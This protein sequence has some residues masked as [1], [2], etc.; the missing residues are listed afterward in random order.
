MRDPESRII[1]FLC[2]DFVEHV[3][4]NSLLRNRRKITAVDIET[5]AC[6]LGWDFAS[7]GDDQGEASFDQLDAKDLL[8]LATSRMYEENRESHGLAC[9]TF[10]SADWK[11]TSKN[12]N[13][14]EL[15]EDH[16][17]ERVLPD[18]LKEFVFQ[19]QLAFSTSGTG[20]TLTREEVID[21]LRNSEH[22]SIVFPDILRHFINEIRIRSQSVD[23]SQ[24][25]DVIGAIVSN[26]W[27]QV[28][29]TRE[30]D[31]IFNCLLHTIIDIN[32]M[33]QMENVTYED[34]SRLRKKALE[35]LTKLLCLQIGKFHATEL[36]NGL[37]KD[38]LIPFVSKILEQKRPHDDIVLQ[39]FSAAISS[40]THLG[41]EFGMDS[42]LRP[43][44][45]KI[46]KFCSGIGGDHN[47]A[48]AV[49]ECISHL[50]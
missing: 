45:A 35:A 3:T 1:E 46:R 38:I 27:Y 19:V 6:T 25:L 26:K 39:A 9:Y 34:S 13:N 30:F 2:R 31:L 7:T 8:E 4:R 28:R 40:L 10:S 5:A 22:L 18:G 50:S 11:S 47:W 32:L 20:G 21:A 15:E 36:I 17:S 14:R 48:N 43:L 44:A 24:H 16:I 23:V 41:N 49:L 37:K 42:E 29:S 33:R 12:A